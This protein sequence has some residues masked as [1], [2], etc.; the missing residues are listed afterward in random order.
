MI[1][2]WSSSL[3][4]VSWAPT[5]WSGKARPSPWGKSEPKTMGSMPTSAHDPLDVLLGVR[6][7]DEV[8]AEDLGGASVEAAVVGP[9]GFAAHQEGVVHL[10]QGVGQPDRAHLRQADLDVRESGRRSC[11]G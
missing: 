11:A 2:R 6:G 8:L 7:H 5:Y 3:K 10:A 9:L 1:R 4:P